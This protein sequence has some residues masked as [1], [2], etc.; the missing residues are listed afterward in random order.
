MPS[1]YYIPKCNDKDTLVK[2][3]CKC[4]N[5]T[6]KIKAPKNKANLKITV[7]KRGKKIKKRKPK[8]KTKKKTKKKEPI[9]EQSSLV[10]NQSND[11]I[12]KNNTPKISKE[13]RSVER[14]LS[15][16]YSPSINRRILSL[17]TAPPNKNAHDC[18]G[19]NIKFTTKKGVEKCIKWTSKTGKRIMLNN[20]LSKQKTDCSQIIAPKQLESNCWMNTFFMAWFISDKGR[21]FNRWF[22]ETMITGI[23]PDGLKIPP[24]MKK[25]LWLLNKMIDASLNGRGN[26][27]T[28]YASLMDTNDIIRSIHKAFPKTKFVETK[29]ASNPLTFYRT[30]YSMINREDFLPWFKISA[31]N[32]NIPVNDMIKLEFDKN[33][34]VIGKTK[35][36]FVELFGEAAKARK[37]IEFEYNEKVYKLDSVILRNIK[38]YHFSAYITCN[39]KEYGFDGESYSRMEQFNWKNKINKDKKWRF[40]EKHDTFFNFKKG[41][42]LLIYYREV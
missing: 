12:I 38:G 3:R 33:T 4:K 5:V 26:I 7:K 31:H 14:N 17:K 19:L 28:R 10:T 39:G 20:L 40:A 22:R 13:L 23:T 8:K 42:Q 36:I 34:S 11:L 27:T 21:K 29:K 16:E 30:M 32:S 18:P 1:T 25:P 41:Y 6:I 35:V 24:K 2:S 9:K 15:E 37:K